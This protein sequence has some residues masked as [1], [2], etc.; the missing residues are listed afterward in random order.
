[1]TATGPLDQWLGY[2]D[3]LPLSAAP[4]AAP[5]SAA[6]MEHWHDQNLRT[7]HAIAVLDDRHQRN[8]GGT[9]LEV[10]VERLHQKLDVV[11]EL[12]GAVLQSSRPRGPAVAL[13]LTREGVSW[14]APESPP[15]VGE[16]VL[17]ALDLHACAPAPLCWP[18][19]ILGVHEGELCAR[20]LPM[21]EALGA[22]LERFVFTRHRRSVA[23]ARSP[24][25]GA[26]ASGSSR[27]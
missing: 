10:E 12:L 2:R 8:D 6:E 23:G 21:S 20:F 18:A 9:P 22:A 14:P 5:P 24:D 16:T 25:G 17:V 19:E 11:L 1:M 15:P 4:L 3:C 27:Q 7:L 13:R 26:A